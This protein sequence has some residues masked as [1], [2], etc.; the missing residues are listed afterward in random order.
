M[1]KV[2]DKDCTEIITKSKLPGTDF[3][4]N[5]YIGCSHACMYCYASFMKRFSK[6][7][8]DWGKFLV[9][10]NWQKINLK[11]LAGKR[12]L[13]S[14]VTDPYQPHEKIYRSTNKILQDIQNSGAKIE[15]LTKSKLI[16]NDIDV[17]K[18]IKDLRVGI[19]ISSSD[20]SFLRDIE[21]LAS[22]YEERI[23]I[24]KVLKKA[25]IDTYLFISPIFPEITNFDKIIEDSKDFV[26]EIYFEN[27]NL[28]GLYKK[29][30]LE[31]IKIKYP[32][33]ISLYEK[34]FNSKDFNFEYWNSLKNKISKKYE[35][36]KFKTRIYFFHDEIKKS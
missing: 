21:P 33:K 8:D 30:I 14:S 4:I 27:L 25:G 13:L 32:E 5:P 29:N 16:L 11:K 9:V 34:I 3:V 35:N 23:K 31:Y 18:N 7:E 15:I 26:N 2:W 1:I 19:S 36:A 24:L 6:I 17:L 28:K 10:K 22:S 12:V 20:N